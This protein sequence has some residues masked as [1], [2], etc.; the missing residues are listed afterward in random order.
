MSHNR[1]ELYAQLSQ[2]NK[3]R[4]DDVVDD[5]VIAEIADAIIELESN[6][7]FNFRL[8]DDGAM[9]FRLSEAAMG[10]QES[11]AECIQD[12]NGHKLTEKEVGALMIEY[13]DKGFITLGKLENG[14]LTYALTPAGVEFRE[15]Q[16]AK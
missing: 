9:E 14:D 15:Q 2:D 12:M 1:D 10:L 8:L 16:R 11:L 3:R 13:Q 4:G 6:G 7:F 5:A